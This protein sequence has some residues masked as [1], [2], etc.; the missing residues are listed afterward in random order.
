MLIPM[1]G[2]VIMRPSLFSLSAED[3]AILTASLRAEGWKLP[4]PRPRRAHPRYMTLSDGESMRTNRE[5]RLRISPS[6]VRLRLGRDLLRE[7]SGSLETK[8]V[9]AIVA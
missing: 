2:A 6:R 9:M 7:A 3:P 4:N 1:G 8:V 5:V